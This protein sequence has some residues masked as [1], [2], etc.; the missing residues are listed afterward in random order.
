MFRTRFR[1][2]SGLAAAAATVESARRETAAHSASHE[3]TAESASSEA[4][5]S[6]ESISVQERR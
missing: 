4:G 2:R 5:P 3:T 6:V 1:V